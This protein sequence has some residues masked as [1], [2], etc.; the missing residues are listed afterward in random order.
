MRFASVANVEGLFSHASIVHEYS[1]VVNCT[2]VYNSQTLTTLQITEIL[3]SAWMVTRETVGMIR[4][5][6]VKPRVA[7]VPRD[8][9]Q[10][11]HCQRAGS[12]PAHQIADGS[13]RR[14]PFA[15]ELNHE[16]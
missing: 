15:L 12:E 2:H 13:R 8:I 10:S 9:E 4:E 5:E 11:A 16:R 14:E 1:V 7:P 3:V 6:V